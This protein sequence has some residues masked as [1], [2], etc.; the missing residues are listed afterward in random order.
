MP[1]KQGLYDI[2]NMEHRN[3]AHGCT[4]FDFHMRTNKLFE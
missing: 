2:C 4:L 3:T 1:T